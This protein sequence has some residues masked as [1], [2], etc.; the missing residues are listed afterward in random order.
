MKRLGGIFEEMCEFATLERAFALVRRGKAHKPEVAA[1][2]ANLEERLASIRADLLAGRFRFGGYRFFEIHDPK[3]RTIAAAPVRERVVHHAII[4]VCGERLERS[5]VDR[6]YACRKGKG[7]WQAVAEAARLAARH[8]WCLKLDVRRFFDTIDHARMR[9]ALARKVKDWRVLDLFAD[10]LATY[11]TAPGKGLPIGNLTSQYFANLYLD[12]LDRWLDA[13]GLAHVRYMDDVIAF[14]SHEALRAAFREVPVFLRETLALELKAKGGLHRCDRGVD[15]LGTRVL[16]GRALP[17]KATRRRFRR[18]LRYFSDMFRAGH[19]TEEQFQN[20]MTQRF[21]WIG[22]CA[23]K[24]FRRKAV[25]ENG[26]GE[27]SRRA[28]RLLEQ[29][30][31]RRLCRGMPLRL[32]ELQH[33]QQHEPLQQQQLLGLPCCVSARSSTNK[34]TRLNRPFSGSAPAGGQTQERPRPVPV[35]SGPNATGGALFVEG[36]RGLWPF[37][38]Q[39][40]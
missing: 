13:R 22:H 39:G 36:N 28:R 24:D 30:Q 3:T 31:Q 32:S 11:E 27:L 10:L 34:G 9:R 4:L 16:P 35:G 25:A 26:Q 14:G 5:L 8:P 40:A 12:P 33:Q 23:G 15:F 29:Q 7:Q 37:Y 2:A 6:A 20:R 21:A 18:D 17:S 19:L 1:F 38:H